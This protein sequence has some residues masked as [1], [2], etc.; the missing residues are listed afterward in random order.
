MND[1]IRPYART[2]YA[3]GWAMSGGPMTERVQAG[4]L[5][6]MDLCAE[7]WDQPGILEVAI[8][9]GKL[10]GVWAKVF[11]RR[12]ALMADYTSKIRKVWQQATKDL[13]VAGAIEIYRTAVGLTET[14]VDP[15]WLRR[16]KREARDAAM[17]LLAWLPGTN[18]WQDLRDIM[19]EL[20]RASR[21]EGLADALAVAASAEQHLDYDWELSFQTAYDALAND[22]ALWAE[23]DTWLNRMLGTAAD[24]FGQT[25]GDLAAQGAD[26]KQMLAAGMD[27]LQDTVSDEGTVGFIT[28]WASS[29]GMSKGAL[30]LYKSEGVRQVSWLTAGDGRVCPICEKYGEDSPYPIMD[31]PPMPAHPRCRCVASAEFDISAYSGFFS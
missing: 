21:A 29:F 31:F 27:V 15:E 6:A 12:F 5:V 2:A 16:A 10:E 22:T 23:A 1:A 9:L 20:I 4:C 24:E 11:A 18:S 17:R 3:Q 14:A 8:H 19:R 30:D 28:D 13:D 7:L 26:Y 25:L